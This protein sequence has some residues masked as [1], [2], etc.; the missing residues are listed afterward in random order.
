MVENLSLQKE[1][2]LMGCGFSTTTP[3]L[4]TLQSLCSISF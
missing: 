2:L 1:K 3:L 4:A